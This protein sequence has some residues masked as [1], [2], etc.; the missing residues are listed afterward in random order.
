MCLCQIAT[1]VCAGCG[2]EYFVELYSASRSEPIHGLGRRDPDGHE[3]DHCWLDG[4]RDYDAW[5][6]EFDTDDPDFWHSELDDF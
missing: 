1:R 3:C 5:D 4:E 6:N 2:L